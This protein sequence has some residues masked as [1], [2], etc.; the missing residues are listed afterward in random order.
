MGREFSTLLFG[1]RLTDLTAAVHGLLVTGNA[2]AEILRVTSD[3]RR[4][5]PGD[6]F[7]AIRGAAHDGAEYARDAIERGAVGVL[8]EEPLSLPPEVAM[9]VAS[10]ARQALA[11]VASAL[12]GR[13][14]EQLRLVGVTGTDGKT[15]TSQLIGHVL[16]AAGRKV[17]WM[18]TVDVRI[19]DDIE[20]NPFGYT[21][22]EA[23]EIQETLARMVDAGVEDAVVEVSSHALALERVRDCVF[24]AAVFTN[25]APEHLN[26]HHT[27]EEYTKA[28]ARLFEMLDSP[29]RKR[30]PRMGVVNADDPASMTMVAASPAGIVSYGLNTP[31]DV[32]ADRIEL[33]IG[34]SRF[35]LITPVDQV[36][37]ST[38]LV[39]RHNV[40][41][42]LAA[43]AVTLGWGI[44][45]QAVV[46]AA[47]TATGPAGRLER[48][49][50]GQPFEVIV[51]FAHTPQALESTLSALR[52]FCDGSLYVVFGMPG[53]RDA[54][55]RPRMGE[56][57]AQHA[58]YFVVTTDDPLHE[59]A[60][61][62][63]EQILVGARKAGARR[64]EHYDVELD[65]RSAIASLL[66]RAEPGDVVLLA[67][68]GH[69]QRQ[70][71]G[72][73]VEPWSDVGTATDLLAAMGFA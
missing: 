48:V 55:N 40:Y 42:W 18:T 43:A 46:D 19:R 54:S 62:I 13:P 41:N 69:E 14:S 35:Q 33:G 21:T 57:A 38:R 70:L 20:R 66:A 36:H 58:D 45:L 39:G 5:E 71:I 7:V 29:T 37:V 28:K 22:P 16:A 51:D 23:P 61:D 59:E 68:K 9:V 6:L 50:R 53:G 11:D 73:R 64:G 26:F 1:V 8:A 25:L 17:G 32:M 15:T 10:D 27:V 3:S 24:D 63:A 44:D 67:A 4:V 31:A 56:L 12:H 34:G 65:R 72:D 47:S 30:W 49:R 2:E 52:A 60:A